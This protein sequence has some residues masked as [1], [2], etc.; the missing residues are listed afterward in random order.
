[1]S[2]ARFIASHLEVTVRDVGREVEFYRAHFGAKELLR[3]GDDWALVKVGPLDL[4][5]RRGLTIDAPHFHFGLR[6][7]TKQESEEWWHR[8]SDSGVKIVREWRDH[9]DWADVTVE[10]PAG[11]HVQLF[12]ERE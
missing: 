6:V 1:M 10:T 11:Y 2:A 12:Y 3:E 9:G 5:L 4:A 8:L 7:G